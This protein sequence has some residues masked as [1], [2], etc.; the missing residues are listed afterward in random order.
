MPV[1]PEITRAEGT[2]KT[3]HDPF[4]FI[5]SFIVTADPDAPEIIYVQFIH[6]LRWE[7]TGNCNRCGIADF[8]ILADGSIDFGV[9]NIILESGK[10][11]GEVNSVLDLDQATRLDYPCTPQYDRLQRGMAADM[12]IPYVCGLRFKPLPWIY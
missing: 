4:T 10:S 12:G 7:M 5:E 6:Q 11:I 3:T 2:F 1:Y 8:N 9:H